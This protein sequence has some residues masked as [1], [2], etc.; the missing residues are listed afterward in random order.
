M[1]KLDLKVGESVKI[2]NAVVTLEDKSGKIARLAIQA[3]K[4]VPIQRLQHTPTAAHLAKN[5]LGALPA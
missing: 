2:G 5:G 3:G 1:L 4:D